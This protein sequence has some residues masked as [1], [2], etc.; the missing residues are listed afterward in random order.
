[1]RKA[2]SLFFSASSGYNESPVTEIAAQIMT[3]Q[4][5]HAGAAYESFRQDKLHMANRESPGT[6]GISPTGA[7]P[8][9]GVTAGITTANIAQPGTAS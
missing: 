1:M 5:L 8:P 7:S 9:I 2:R 4:A 6:L 3:A